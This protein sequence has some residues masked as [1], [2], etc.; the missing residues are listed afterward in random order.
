MKILFLS[1]IA[2]SGTS[3]LGK[4]FASHPEVLYHF[5]PFNLVQERKNL[6]GR[7][8]FWTLLPELEKLK[9]ADKDEE[10]INKLAIPLDRFW[11]VRDRT[12]DRR[13]YF[14]QP[15]Q[16]KL[17]AIKEDFTGVVEICAY[18]GQVIQIVRD[19]RAVLNSLINH[20]RFGRHYGAKSVAERWA[21]KNSRFLDLQQ[22]QPDRFKVV[23]YE[24]LCQRPIPVAQDLVEWAGLSFSKPVTNF[25][26]A[27]HS[28]HRPGHYEVYKN[29]T[30]TMNDWRLK[31]SPAIQEVVLGQVRGSR[32]AVE[33]YDDFNK[34]ND[35]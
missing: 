7:L 17:M 3:W 8:K 23:K 6:D 25:L 32:V 4:I 9:L 35:A 10:A 15:Q 14:P 20:T 31:L 30:H 24:E 12:L 13:P 33:L 5:E 21:E 27:S 2:R 22:A 1:G 18:F 34:H 19:P 26:N 29:P 28:K 11:D 16:P